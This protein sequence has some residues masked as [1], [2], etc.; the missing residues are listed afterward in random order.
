MLQEEFRHLHTVQRRA[1]AQVVAGD[2]KVDRSGF[3]RVFTYAPDEYRKQVQGMIRVLQNRY[4][5][6]PREREPHV[7]KSVEAEQVGFAW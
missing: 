7:E 3:G 5:L 6:T 2:P 1:L 4:G